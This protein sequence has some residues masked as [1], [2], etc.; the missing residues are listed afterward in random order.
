MS[1]VKTAETVG[2]VLIHVVTEKGRGY[3]PAE[4]AQ[5][6][7]VGGHQGLSRSFDNVR[8]SHQLWT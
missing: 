1:E 7:L 6:R 2:P 3:I 8:S 4:V 5:V